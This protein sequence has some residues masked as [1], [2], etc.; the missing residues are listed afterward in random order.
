[1]RITMFC[2]ARAALEAF[3]GHWLC[4]PP[5]WTAAAGRPRR[6][7]PDEPFTLYDD[8]SQYR[9]RVLRHEATTECMWL[10]PR[11]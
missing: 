6:P 2:R 4:S 7:D 3:K 11:T 5:H 8:W 1:M 10:P 9:Q